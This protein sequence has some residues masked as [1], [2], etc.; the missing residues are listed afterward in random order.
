MPHLIYIPIILF[1]IYR[2][3]KVYD[4]MNRKLENNQ[5]ALVES[6]VTISKNEDLNFRKIFFFEDSD[7]LITNSV[8][9]PETPKLN[10][11]QLTA[12]QEKFLMQQQLIIKEIENISNSWDEENIIPGPNK[13]SIEL[14]LEIIN[15]LA[16]QNIHPNRI[17]PSVE[18]GM[19]LTF[20]NNNRILYFELYNDGDI[21]Y[22]I[23]DIKFNRII[24]NED[25]NSTTEV[26]NKI[27]HFFEI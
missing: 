2:L 21:G 1:L 19:C 17:T 14:T 27:S 13:K 16:V 12:I 3:I 20:N 5:A 4:L 26:L 11:N 23:E 7:Y 6:V 15:N 24:E 22:I 8:F 25:V 18:E 10:N 9:M